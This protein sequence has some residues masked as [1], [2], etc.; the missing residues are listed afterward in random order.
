MQSPPTSTVQLPSLFDLLTPAASPGSSGPSV[1]DSL[2][3]PP[4]A[5]PGPPPSSDS[6][7]PASRNASQPKRSDNDS[8]SS[9][10]PPADSTASTDRTPPPQ[11]QR[12]ENQNTT[13][14]G[15]P[16]DADNKAQENTERP[17]EENVTAQSL[18]GLAAVQAATSAPHEPA[19]ED[20]GNVPDSKVAGKAKTPAGAPIDQISAN[21]DAAAS[22]AEATKDQAA[23]AQHNSA[24]EKQSSASATSSDGTNAATKPIVDPAGIQ[25]NDKPAAE[26]TSDATS[27][28][29]P[30]ND[31]KAA[32][33]Q[34]SNHE[35]DRP[36][37]DP[38]PLAQQV[39]IDPTTQ[40]VTTNPTTPAAAPVAVPLPAH[41]P[42]ANQPAGSSASSS[43]TTPLGAAT[44]P[45]SRLPAETLAP[46]PRTAARA[47][48]TEI[49]TARL[50]SRVAKAFNAAQERDGEVRL[51][52]SPPELGA[53]RLEVRVQ[54]G[55]MVAHLHTETDSARTALIDNLPA[56]RDRLAEQG[57]RIDRFDV[58]LMQRQP[59]GSPDQPGGRQQDAP[60]PMRL[61]PPPKPRAAVAAGP[62]A[63]MP[64]SA[65]ASGLNVI[66]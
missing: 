5:P 30:V 59:G 56:L 25:A 28:I 14:G 13:T 53:L 39:A 46:G 3:Q 66:V 11:P 7:I 24:A 34:P 19:P 10:R 50:L 26:A 58:D 38:N 18:A 52:L 55:A 4:T 12:N 32:N 51:R 60:A 9:A 65:A 2:L 20:A 31:D 21:G 54:D 43:G 1:F 41:G 17:A 35:S 62:T 45:R 44:G 57:V 27:G 6:G 64:A 33:N 36:P 37:V 15:Q 48:P 8:L 47:A 16:P 22:T 49:D 29:L 63:S 40:P 61:A 23:G 42:S